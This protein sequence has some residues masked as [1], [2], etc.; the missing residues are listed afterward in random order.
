MKVKKLE[1]NNFRGFRKATIEF[2]DSNL[3]VFIGTNG[4]GKSSILDAVAIMLTGFFGFKIGSEEDML[5]NYDDIRFGERAVEVGA[6]CAFFNDDYK[7][8]NQLAL[9]G[10][11]ISRGYP[12]KGVFSGDYNPNILPILAYYKTNRE[13]VPTDTEKANR[14][15]GRTSAYHNAISAGISAFRDFSEWFR[16]EEDI[17]NQGKIERQDFKYDSPKLKPIRRSVTELL[18][19]FDADFSELKVRRQNEPEIDFSRPSQKFELSIKKNGEELKLSQLSSGER[20]L[21][22][23]V[24]DIARRAAV[25]NPQLPDPLQSEGIVLIDEIELHLH[26][27]WQREVIPALLATFPNIQFLI[28]THSPQVLSRVDKED[29]FL[30]ENGEVFKLSSNPKGLDT[31]AILEEIMDTPKYPQHVDDLVAKLFT[32]IQQKKFDQA[33]TVREQ[34]VHETSPE[35]PIL[36]QADSM[37]ERLKVLYP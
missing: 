31:N 26:P 30:L 25:L 2:P 32:L 3:A 7:I 13:L 23:L 33:G 21:L 4:K 20:A 27:K 24:A 12:N 18:S 17:E 11:P 14:P 10:L 36:R 28:T 9:G 34:I 6:Q 5:L 1:L 35:Y 37:M 15:G 8:S 29:I 22:L 19:K 16:F